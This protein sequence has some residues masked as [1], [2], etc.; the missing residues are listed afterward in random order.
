MNLLAKPYYYLVCQVLWVG[1]ELEFHIS[2]DNYNNDDIDI[3]IDTVNDTD[4]VTDTD[5][6]TDTYTDTHADTDT[7]SAIDADTDTDADIDTNTDTDS[8]TDTV[9]DNHTQTSES[10]IFLLSNKIQRKSNI[11]SAFRKLEDSE[12]LLFSDKRNEGRRCKQKYFNHH[13]DRNGPLNRP[14]EADLSR[15]MVKKGPLEFLHRQN[16]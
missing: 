4:T 2:S 9:T 13:G 11:Y 10:P 14:C 8:N 15:P 3:D 6:D 1:E 5:T 16:W 7:D 12:C